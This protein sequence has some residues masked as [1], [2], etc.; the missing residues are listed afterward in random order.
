MSG[1]DR[2][3][4]WAP[5]AIGRCLVLAVAWALALAAVRGADAPPAGAIASD[6]DDDDDDGELARKH[7]LLVSPEWRQAIGELDGWLRTQTIYPPAEVRRI[8]ARFNTWVST[9]S[10]YELEY[11]LGS[12]SAKL[13]LL[14]TPE[15][16]DAKAWLGEYLAAM[17]DGRRAQAMQN[18]PDIFSLSADELWRE[19]E[20]VDA[21]RATLRE[22][23]Q[24]VESRQTVLSD[25]AAAGRAATAAASRTAAARPRSAPSHS[26]YRSGG[27]SAPFANAQQRRAQIVI[28][29]GGMF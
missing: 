18:V 28:M 25:R 22:R 16:R 15:A 26:P 12:I 17:S 10:S 1:A 24:G 14:S 6:D 27:G 4:L 3:Y 2:R 5:S 9:M 29:S 23:Q 20:R 21:L 7:D 11:L 8:K 19:I 13:E